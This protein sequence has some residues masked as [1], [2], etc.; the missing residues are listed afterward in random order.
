MSLYEGMNIPHALADKPAS[1]TRRVWCRSRPE[2]GNSVVEF[3]G[4]VT[5]EVHAFVEDSAEFDVAIGVDAIQE[6]MSWAFDSVRGGA[7]G[8]APAVG[9][10]IRADVGSDFIA[11]LAASAIGVLGNVPDGS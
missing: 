6:E 10:M 5:L 3:V 9:E 4:E 2:A 11:A 8:A 7:G 1:G